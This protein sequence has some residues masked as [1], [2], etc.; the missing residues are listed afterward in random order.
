MLYEFAR[1]YDEW[2]DQPHS[3]SSLTGALAALGEHGVCL[4]S[5]WP[6]SQRDRA[7]SPEALRAARGNQPAAMRQVEREVEAIRQRRREAAVADQDQT[8]QTLV[9]R[10]E[11]ARHSLLDAEKRMQD[12]Q[13]EVN[14]LQP[15]RLIMRFIEERSRSSDYRSRLGI[16]SLV[17]RDF[18]RL[19]ELADPESKEHNAELMPVERIILYVDDFDRCKPER[20]I[21]VLETVHL[22]LA[23]RLFMVVVAVDPRWL[24]HCL[25]RHYPDLLS[26]SGA[27]RALVAH[28]LP[29]RPATA[30]DYLEKIFQIPFLLQPLK[31]DGF[32]RL[33]H[34][35]TAGGVVAEQIASVVGQSGATPTGKVVK[36]NAGPE[37]PAETKTST[38]TGRAP[39]RAAYAAVEPLSREAVEWKQLCATLLRLSESDFP[40][41]QVHELQPWVRVVARYSFTLTA[42]TTLLEG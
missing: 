26:V 36:S 1:R 35:L 19:S 3:G 37:A 14:E 42:T 15:G 8:L 38:A 40:G 28:V 31:D 16:V 39:R 2:A 32:R 41:I 25:E 6:L 13:H 11:A 27:P 7:A 9:A 12:L 34:G 24:R 22:L 23:F 33:V 4:D 17:R 5:E 30:Q 20:V 21:E 10:E 29:S 18:E